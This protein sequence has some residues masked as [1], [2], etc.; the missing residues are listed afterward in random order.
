VNRS[1]TGAFDESNN[2]EMFLFGKTSVVFPWRSTIADD[3]DGRL[4]NDDDGDGVDDG[5]GDD[6]DDDDVVPLRLASVAVRWL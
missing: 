3:A 2:K 6:G 4:D 5:D 1:L